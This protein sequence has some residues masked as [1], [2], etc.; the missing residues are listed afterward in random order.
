MPFLPLFGGGGP[1]VPDVPRTVSR[2]TQLLA[3]ALPG[4]RY[5]SFER[6]PP[7]I[8]FLEG[9]VVFYPVIEGRL[10]TPRPALVG[11]IEYEPAIEGQW[12]RE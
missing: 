11:F 10:G 7:Q 9:S 8:G 12:G 1:S 3:H 5:G 6:F 4:R 2:F